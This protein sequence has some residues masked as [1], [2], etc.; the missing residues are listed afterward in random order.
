[1]VTYYLRDNAEQE[2][3]KKL[4]EWYEMSKDRAIKEVSEI[5]GED[6]EE[7]IRD[8]LYRYFPGEEDRIYQRIGQTCNFGYGFRWDDWAFPTDIRRFDD[9]LQYIGKILRNESEVFYTIVDEDGNE[10]TYEEFS[11]IV[12]NYGQTGY[13]KISS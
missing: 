1:M 13:D 8:N 6:A 3:Q 7:W 5:I 9:R 4:E 2:R 12:R 11:E 10:L